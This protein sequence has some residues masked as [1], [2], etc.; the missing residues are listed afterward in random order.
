MQVATGPNHS[1]VVDDPRAVKDALARAFF[2]AAEAQR[3][4]IA[5][6]ARELEARDWPVWVRRL[7][8]V[9]P[10]EGGGKPA[11]YALAA[12]TAMPLGEPGD[13]SVRSDHALVPH[14][15]TSATPRAPARSATAVKPTHEP[16]YSFP[17]RSWPVAPV[18]RRE[19]L[20]SKL[21]F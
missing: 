7:G 21:N 17:P 12:S 20:G 19:R 13:A 4:I 8:Q 5:Q 9:M 11:G 6:L 2:R 10:P 1:P 16:R 3:W 15:P 18:Q 14:S